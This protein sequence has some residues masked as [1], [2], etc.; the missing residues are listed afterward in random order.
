M[1][2]LFNTTAALDGTSGFTQTVELLT[3][4]RKLRAPHEYVV[5]TTAAQ[6]R[7]RYELGTGV[8]HL[9]ADV[10]S[11]GVS[12]TPALWVRLPGL[13]RR[14]RIDVLYNRGNFFAP[15]VPCRQICL[16]ENAN[17]F[18]ELDLPDP[19]GVR[20]R[21]RLLRY[22]S[23][24]ALKHADAVVFPSRSSHQK[25][26]HGRRVNARQFVIPHGSEMPDAPSGVV[27]LSQPYILIVGTIFPFKNLTVAL[28]ALHHLKT[29]GRF[30]GAVV[31]I[32]DQGRHPYMRTIVAE[33][34]R[35]GI[36]NE[37]HI[38][39]PLSRID[40]VPW[41]RHATVALTTSVEE[42]FGLPVVEAM[43]LGVPVVAPDSAAGE[44]YFLPFRE[45]CAD[46]A[47]YFDPFDA[48]TCADAIARAITEP[49]RSRMIEA[50]QARTR[51]FSW[52]AAA[53]RTAHMFDE[54]RGPT[55]TRLES[56]ASKSC[57]D[58]APNGTTETSA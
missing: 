48:R 18:S 49:R 4:L 12:R 51:E 50:G 32:G 45:I 35:L 30:S 20:V 39:P 54:M 8:E 17:P 2:V 24:A 13:L 29:A 1:R 34:E 9:I 7:L 28:Q 19:L 43:N 15:R 38:Y 25:I 40:L 47:E 36:R 53:R 46:A 26:T 37:V 23:E 41:Y 55:I 58:S 21:N 56:D 22:M 57:L 27:T 5:L 3:A 10:P 33:M 31:M 52:E 42:T 14:G 16:I 6:S 11:S 44:R